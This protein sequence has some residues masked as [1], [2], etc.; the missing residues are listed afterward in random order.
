VKENAMEKIVIFW[1]LDARGMPMYDSPDWRT[2]GQALPRGSVP[3]AVV[4]PPFVLRL[5][6]FDVESPEHAA[7]E[8]TIEEAIAKLAG[9][10]ARWLDVDV[11][12]AHVL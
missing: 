3:A 10:D 11:G 8:R 1:V 2:S 12:S 9:F 6:E 7:I 5:Y 4:A